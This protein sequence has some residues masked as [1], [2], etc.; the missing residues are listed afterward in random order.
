[1]NYVSAV[2]GVVFAL[3]M[4]YWFRRGKNTFRSKDE[5]AVEAEQF[6]QNIPQNIH[7]H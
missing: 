2:Y 3:I 7:V 5:R 4:G 1:M 6:I